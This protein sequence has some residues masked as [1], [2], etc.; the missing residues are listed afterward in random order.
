VGEALDHTRRRVGSPAPA[1]Q[2]AGSGGPRWKQRALYDAVKDLSALCGAAPAMAR[3]SVN[4]RLGSRDLDAILTSQI[5]VDPELVRELV[6]RRTLCGTS[7][8]PA[9]L[10]TKHR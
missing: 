3:L 4:D 7:A 10:T 2:L 1:G 8:K 6:D 9:Q 5:A